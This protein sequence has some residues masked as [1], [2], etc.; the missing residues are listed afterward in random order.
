MNAKV[1]MAKLNEIA[2]GALSEADSAF[3]C[4]RLKAEED[5]LLRSKAFL[6][7]EKTGGEAVLAAVRELIVSDT[8]R[9]WQLRGLSV[10]C[11]H[12][13]KENLPV[14]RDCLFQREKPLLIR[15]ALLAAADGGA[16]SAPLLA[17]F[18]TGPFSGYLKE[19]FLGA[20]LHRFAEGG[21]ENAAAW[22][23]M[24]QENAALASLDAVLRAKA[25]ENE[26]LTVYPYPDY[27]SRRAE[28]K[29]Y[30]HKEWKTVSFFPRKKRR[31][32]ERER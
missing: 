16:E 18:L 32:K 30:T 10:L 29:G 14:L 24:L 5:Y 6:V 20:C 8:E 15:G 25:D 11:R 21:A 1:T 28:E 26:L 9:E 19:D 12:P 2:T 7:A 17:A 3:L 31:Q 23:R 27:L 22:E 4:S 13:S